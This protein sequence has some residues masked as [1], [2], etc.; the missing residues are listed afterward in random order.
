MLTSQHLLKVELQQDTKASDLE[1]LVAALFGRLLGV[2]IAVA[3]SGFQHGGDAGPA[4][5]QGRRFRL[6]CKKYADTSQLNR[7]ELLGE[8]DHALA[9]DDALEAWILVT[10]RSVPEQQ[11]QDVAQHGESLGVPVV[12]LDWKDHEL[13]PF[14]ALCAF[15]PPLMEALFSKEAAKYAAWPSAC[16]A[17]EYRP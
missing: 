11:A 3:G 1:K 16:Q 7:R 17:Q 2:P 14:A 8:I 4:G 5:R 9:R 13:T 6:E 10:T 15:D 12:I